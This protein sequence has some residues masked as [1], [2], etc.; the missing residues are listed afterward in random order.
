MPATAGPQGDDWTTFAHDQRRTGY[1]AQATGITTATA[2]S[3]QL[4]WSVSLDEPV[5]ASPLVAGGSVYVAGEGGT[6]AALDSASGATLWRVSLGAPIYMTPT[7]DGGVLYVGTHGQPGIL[8]AIDAASGTIRWTASLPGA[9][10]SEPVVLDGVLYVGDASGDP[11]IC[12]RGGVHGFQTAT[13]AHVFDWYD[14]PKTADGGAVWN[15]ISTDGQALYLGTGNTCSPNVSDANAA[16]KLS[17]SGATLWAHNTATPLSD[18]D[19]GS[20]L[21]LAGSDAIGSDKNGTL[22]DFDAVSGSI[23]WSRKLGTLDG[24][25]P[26]GSVATDGTIIVTSGGYVSDPTQTTGNPGGWLYGLERDGSILWRIQTPD[27]VSGDTPITGGVAFAAG[28]NDLT[29]YDER[30]GAVLWT[31]P[32]AA[33]AYPSP[34]LVPSGV[35]AADYGGTIYAFALR[36]TATK[37]RR[38]SRVS[39]IVVPS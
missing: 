15:P 9:I 20:A 21:V 23:V 27:A 6:V 22:Y 39:R 8:D 31:Y 10:R 13:G 34:A 3:L 28:G 33:A 1:Q 4:R 37:Q 18:D 5:R 2:R 24:Y 32:F 14:D 11:P 12:N 25:G 26:I 35:Y 17:P 19:F 36:A 30:S 38:G 7:L 16:V 29:A